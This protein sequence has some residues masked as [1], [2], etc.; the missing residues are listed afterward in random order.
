[1]LFLYEK[2]AERL[3]ALADYF[4]AGLDRD[5][6]CVFVTP[7]SSPKVID[8]FSSLGLHLDQAVED[9]DFRIFEMA[10]TY[11]PHGKFIA[12]YMLVNVANFVIEAKAKGYTGIRTAGEMSWLD[13]HP[14]FLVGATHYETQINGL[15]TTNPEFTGLCLYPVH[16]G[17]S[18]LIDSALQTHP[19]FLY[20]GT[21][22]TNPFYDKKP[23]TNGWSIASFRKS[24]SQPTQA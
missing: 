22:E 21:V 17:S 19:N 18:K 12:N 2:P 16:E 7:D 24:I 11:L 4:G 10:E 8:D 6:L 5:E 15:D 23:P 3:R 9:G 13:E 1:M 14:E 20:D